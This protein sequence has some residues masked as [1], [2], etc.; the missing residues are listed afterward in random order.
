MVGA[1]VAVAGCEG[2]VPSTRP[3]DG[4]QDVPMDA[5][6][7]MDRPPG[8]TCPPAAPGE[9]RGLGACCTA[10][11]NCAGG[12]CWNGF[13]TKTCATGAECGP[14]VAPSPLPVGT[15][16]A[17]AVNKVGDPFSY[18]LPGSLADCTGA[19][20]SC[21]DGQGC[22]LGLAPANA[23]ASAAAAYQGICLTR[24]RADAY[25]PAGAAC[26]AED[27][28]YACEDQGGYLG[29]GCYSGRCTRAC[30]NNQMCP[31]GMQCRL[32]PYSPKLGGGVSYQTPNTPGIC[33]GRLC[34]A[35]HGEAGLQPGQVTQQGADALCVTGEVCAPTMAVGASGD[36]QL[37]SC[38]PPRAGALPFG[39]ACS[40]DAASTNRCADDG[41]C[42]ARGGARFCSRLCRV[43]GDCPSGSF[44]MEDYPSAPL[45]NG[46]TAKLAMCTPR[47]MI[48]GT[49]CRV[50]ADCA[51][52]EACLPAGGRTTLLVCRAATGTKPVGAAC[53]SAAECRSGECVDR[54]LHTPTGANRT[55]CGGFCSKNSE[56][57]AGQLCLRVVRNN[58]ATNDD[59][60]DDV[61]YGYCTPLAAPA[62]GGGCAS[63]DNCTGAISID[64]TGGD[65]CDLTYRTCYTKA[66]RI[67]D[68]C[69]TRADCPLGAYC[70]AIDPRFPGGVCLSQGCD[71]AA[72]S[73]V[74]ACPTG[75]VCLQRSTDSPVGACYEA[76]GAGMLCRR[77]SEGYVCEMPVTGQSTSICIGQGGP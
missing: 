61:R 76:C 36:T 26:R 49:G 60:R 19:G 67:G 32:P 68:G 28:P 40:T 52:T 13:C 7:G 15:A 51:A 64:E 6:A 47:A 21:P 75:A 1:I 8:V 71:P 34:G 23:T 72:A 70:R 74:D 16:M 44:C 55:A 27:G 4:G 53:A 56:C 43:D 73:G 69:V 31:I 41:L 29:S 5:P 11:S 18:C 39:E 65:T 30:T 42:V 37:L 59:T 14:V 9:L 54:D 2:G 46:S 3:T 17:C 25:Q 12:V 33:L 48:P 50:E 24:L 10:A 35:V 66:A 77:A 22:A 38:V 57:A 63:D 20:T 62:M 58:N 45:P